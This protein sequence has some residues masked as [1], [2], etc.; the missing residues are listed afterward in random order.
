MIQTASSNYSQPK[1]I[2][3][4]NNIGL[5]TKD[6]DPRSYDYQSTML[7]SSKSYQHGTS[8]EYKGDS[9]SSYEQYKPQ[10]KSVRLSSHNEQEDGIDFI[11]DDVHKDVTLDNIAIYE[12]LVS[13]IQSKLLFSHEDSFRV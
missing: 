3:H 10:Q 7:A 12:S 1:H 8:H 11:E 2:V 9:K 6:P 4:G 5:Y 13:L